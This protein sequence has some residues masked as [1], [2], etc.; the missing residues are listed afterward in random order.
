MSTAEL[1]L[2]I[3]ESDKEFAGETFHE[4]TP[5]Q[6]KQLARAKRKRGRVRRATA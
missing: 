4:P 3:A 1:E 2:A 6:R 5:T